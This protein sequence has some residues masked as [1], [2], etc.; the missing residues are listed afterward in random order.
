MINIGICLSEFPGKLELQALISEKQRN[1]D[2]SGFGM[3]RNCAAW[4][5][6]YISLSETNR[7]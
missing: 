1:E 2:D 6:I 7:Q 5:N 3:I 4:P